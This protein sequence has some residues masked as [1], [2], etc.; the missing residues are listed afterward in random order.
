M[1]FLDRVG[2]FLEKLSC[3]LCILMGSIMVIITA[4][5][6]FTRFLFSY[7]IIWS[8]EL[9]RYMFVWITFL[10]GSIVLKR[11]ELARMTILLERLPKPFDKVFA[12]A[13]ELLILFFS[14]YVTRYGAIQALNV[15]AQLSP[16]LHVSMFWVYLSIPVGFGMIVFYTVNK[17]L[18]IVG[19][20]GKTKCS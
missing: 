2:S 17:M 18:R 6:V 12:F 1:A 20:G 13:V 11:V 3:N 16:A 19:I 8:N 4:L 9:A 10:G 15:K 7:S 5:N 14:V